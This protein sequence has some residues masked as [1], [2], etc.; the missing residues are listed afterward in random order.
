VE[1]ADTAAQV[2][3]QANAFRAAEGRRAQRVEPALAAAAEG[4]ARYMAE[5]GRYGH[6]A[7]GRTPAARAAAQGYDYCIVLENIARVYRSRGYASAE[8]L[9][10]ELLEGW[11]Q[12]PPHRE[13]LLDGAATQTGVGIALDARGAYFAVQLFGR[14]KSEAIRFSVTNAANAAIGYRAGEQSF[15]LPPRTT[16]EHTVCRP[17]SL[18]LS[19]EGGPAFRETVKDGVRYTVTD[20]AVQRARR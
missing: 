4:F 5:S 17:L 12:S 8:A 18:A 3:E 2:V 16:R 1:L 6:T 9:A 19:V 13:A 20:K 10:G 11:K 7:D 14:P 15:D